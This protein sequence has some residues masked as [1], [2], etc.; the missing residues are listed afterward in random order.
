MKKQ[1]AWGCGSMVEH[2]THT[3]EALG[4]KPSIIKNNNKTEQKKRKTFLLHHIL[5]ESRIKFNF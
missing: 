4:W 5:Y 3:C 2:V 1:K